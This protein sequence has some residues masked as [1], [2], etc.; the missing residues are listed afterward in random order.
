M[1]SFLVL[2]EY[3]EISG[4]WSPHTAYVDRES[5][6][7]KQATKAMSSAYCIFMY[8]E[9]RIGDNTALWDPSI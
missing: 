6:S 3:S 8:M 1:H 7:V 2:G 9:K 5:S 4:P